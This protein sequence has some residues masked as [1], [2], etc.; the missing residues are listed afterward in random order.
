M[1]ANRF[2]KWNVRQV[3]SAAAPPQA[4]GGIS[5]RTGMLW[6]LA[7]NTV[8]AL[9][10][11]G[12]L[13]VLARAGDPRSVGLYSLGLAVSAP[14]FMLLNLHLRG[15]Q[16]TDS[17]GEYLTSDYLT[18]RLLTSALALLVVVLLAIG[19]YPGEPL[20][21]LLWLGVAKALESFSDILYGAMQARER[22]DLVG[23]SLLWRGPLSLLGLTVGFVATDSVAWA[24][25]G[26]ALANGVILFLHDVPTLRGGLRVLDFWRLHVPA[27]IRLTRLTLPLGMVMGLIS[28]GANIPRY[29][30][31]AE[32]GQ[33]A[34]GIFSALSYLTVA[35]YLVV[36]AIGQAATVRLAQ[37]HARGHFNDFWRLLAKLFASG[38]LLGASGIAV[39]LMLGRPLIT[40]LYGA[41]YADYTFTLVW[42]MIGGA[43]NYVAS[44]AGYG[45]TAVR[46]FLEQLPLFILVTLV[47]T[48][49]C[50]ALV[51]RY[52]LNGAAYAIVC[53]AVVQ[54]AGSLWIIKQ[55]RRA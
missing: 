36:N 16:T 51:P 28:L 55:S 18:L 12:M 42:L 30:I 7:S 29:F 46:R 54:L 26:V 9:S 24:A 50:S 43:V 48:L 34:L 25:A 37:L 17:R 4:L 1:N 10:Q 20:A 6:T 38:L 47:L 40:L 23:R 14:V 41:E 35:G 52:G 15:A 49:G 2:L 53:A 13:C 21:V 19:A 44:Y 5:M 32:L 39:V 22:L 11:W 8:Y 27:L 31:E 33:T 3:L 45:I